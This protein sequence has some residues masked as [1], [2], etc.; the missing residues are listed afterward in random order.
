VI[1][2]ESVLVRS[3]ARSRIGAGSYNSK[4]KIRNGFCSTE[5]GR[6]KWATGGDV[7]S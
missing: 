1:A 4:E 3:Y 7:A 6:E 2:F 5:E